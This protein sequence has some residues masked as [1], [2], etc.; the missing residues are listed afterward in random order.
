MSGSSNTETR[1]VS[2]EKGDVHASDER[3]HQGDTVDP[4]HGRTA[5]A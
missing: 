1:I 4:F 5:S 3:Q 2:H